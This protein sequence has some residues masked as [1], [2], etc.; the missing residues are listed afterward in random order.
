MD[1]TGLVNI[2]CGFDVQGKKTSEVITKIY[3]RGCIA[4]IQSYV[5]SNLY[6]VGAIAFG[7]ALAQLFGNL[8]S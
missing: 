1:Y 3:T 7:V 6:V 8:Q 4:S 2:M 5:E